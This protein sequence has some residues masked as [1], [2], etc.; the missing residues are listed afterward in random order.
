MPVGKLLWQY[1][2]P[3]VVGTI[4]SSLYN[5][6][7][8]AFI[9]QGVGRDAIS[10]LTL[11]FPFMNFIIAFGML[12]GIGAATRISISLGENNHEK[13]NK[14]LANAVLLL[15]SIMIVVISMS[16]IFMTKILYSLGGSE[17]T[18]SYAKDY[19]VI[20]IPSLIFGTF[21]YSF[22]NIMRASGYPNK[23][24]YTMIISA[25][26]NVILDPIFIFV[27]NWGISGAA[28]ATA[29]SMAISCVWVMMHFVNKKSI[30]YFQKKYFKFDKDIILHI[31]SIG[32]SPFTM[33]IVMS[34]VIV[35]INLSLLKYGGDIAVGAYGILVSITTL[36]IMIIIGIN[37][38][39]QPII[40]FNYGAKKID[41]MIHVIKDTTLAGTVIST[42]GFLAGTFFPVL[43]TK[44]FTPDSQLQEIAA[45]GLRISV[46]V[47]PVVGAQIVFTNFFQSI[48][49][50]KISLF[51]SLTRQVI[52]LIPA[53]YILPHFF[54]LN[55]VWYSMPA[56]DA[57]SAIVTSITF[58]IFIR[59][60][61][62]KKDKFAA[63]NMQDI[64]H[65][66]NSKN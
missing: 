63:V 37:Q 8:R 18:I 60:F 29:I 23:A 32:L 39:A 50:A 33:Q 9:G 30:V 16:M 47:Y 46:L 5:I 2:L 57:M 48:G 28:F 12:V 53:L 19:M 42:I 26:I 10:G 40:G 21:A 62:Q 49:K 65:S 52:F 3:A 45:N 11:T 7:D 6:V 56:S 36:I 13:A 54:Q 61:H 38:G 22:N 41:R 25:G 20:T 58:F 44:V 17:N 14:I 24:M 34:T 66:D 59:K 51:L 31:I 64:K 15:L 43:L 1:S 27:F 35:I 4:V 55:G